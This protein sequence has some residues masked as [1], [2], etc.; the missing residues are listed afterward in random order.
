MGNINILL[1]T[2][3]HFTPKGQRKIFGVLR[4]QNISCDDINNLSVSL[5]NEVFQ[6]GVTS[7]DVIADN[8]IEFI[9]SSCKECDKVNFE[10]LISQLNQA[11]NII[12]GNIAI[13]KF[14]Q[15]FSLRKRELYNFA[16]KDLK[17]EKLAEQIKNFNPTG[18][19]ELDAEVFASLLQKF[20]LDIGQN[21][22]LNIFI[23][24][25]KN[26][27]LRYLQHAYNELQTISD[28][29][30]KFA[31]I[32]I[33]PTENPEIRKLEKVLKQKYR[34][35]YIHLE[36]VEQA[37]NVKKCLE[38]ATQKNIPIPNNIIVTPYFFENGI[39]GLNRLSSDLKT[40]VYITAHPLQ[41]IQYEL[42]KTIP[43]NVK[44][45]N[46][47][48][49]DFFWQKL[50]LFSTERP[51]HIVMHEFMHSKNPIL[52]CNKKIHKKYMDVINNLSEYAK[53]SFNIQNDEV[54]NELLTKQA[55]EE[56]NKKEQEILNIL[57]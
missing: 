35:D 3:R 18:N 22:Y 56:L 48:I 25:N 49:A 17:D 38:I 34:L 54:R 14:A 6:K 27:N 5:R 1:N 24:K 15:I 52:L 32:I 12:Q 30:L 28:K 16:K 4:K 46:I 57:S 2:M 51:E 8:L 7:K 33:P 42:L 39:S 21:K 36:N 31:K 43:D 20:N 53:K 26:K 37:K 11:T 19:I 9:K 29:M 47:L 10:K 50:K 44:E 41:N 13:K 40:T 55:L 45:K 23:D